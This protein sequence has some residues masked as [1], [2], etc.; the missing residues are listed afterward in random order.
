MNPASRAAVTQ[1]GQALSDKDPLIRMNSARALF[2]LEA[3]ARPA[4]PELIKGCQ[5]TDNDTN[6]N[7]FLLTVHQQM[8]LALGRASVDTRRGHAHPDGRIEE[9]RHA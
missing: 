5:A 6:N 8:V 1:L 9:R 3:D 2:Q 4:V 7:M